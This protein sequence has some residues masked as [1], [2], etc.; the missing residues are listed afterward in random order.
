MRQFLIFGDHGSDEYGIYISG[1][2]TF[3]APKR[4]VETVTVPGR[5]GSLTIDNGRYE[6]IEVSY[7]AYIRQDFRLSAGAARDWLLASAGYR[8]LEDT[9]H[10]EFYRMGRF[11]GPL[12]F[13][14]RFLNMSGECTLTFDC[15]PQRFDKA[16]EIPV[17]LSAAGTLYNPYFQTAKPLIRVYGTAAG[18]LTVGSVIVQIK[19]ID[20]YVDLDSE[21]QN[22]YKGATNC[23]GN[24]YVPEFP[25]LP[26][27]TTGVSWSGGITS[28]EITPRWWT[29]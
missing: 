9:Y 20:G 3:N 24:I 8:R 12:D 25:S 1:A 19:A 14:M 5:N 22:A 29:V 15:L 27:G 28:V 23:N 21:T 6:N 10:P 26:A 18:N 13:D 17:T 16:G 11:T 4:D 7:E 2:G